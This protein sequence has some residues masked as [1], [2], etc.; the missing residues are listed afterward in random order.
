[1]GLGFR[2][3]FKG[4]PLRV[5]YGLGVEGIRLHGTHIVYSISI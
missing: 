1:M 3:S 2:G 4:V 5:L